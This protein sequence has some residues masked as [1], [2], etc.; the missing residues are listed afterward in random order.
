MDPR[1]AFNRIMKDWVKFYL[2]VGLDSVDQ[3]TK[4]QPTTSNVMRSNFVRSRTCLTH[5]MILSASLRLIVRRCLNPMSY[6]VGGACFCKQSCR[7]A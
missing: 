7:A 5:C 3:R 4:K 2:D 6:G 1:D